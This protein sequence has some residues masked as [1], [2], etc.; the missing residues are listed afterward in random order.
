MG[1]GCLNLQ[2]PPSNPPVRNER[3]TSA[4]MTGF[5]GKST[6]DERRVCS[7]TASHVTIRMYVCV[8]VA[9]VGGKKMVQC[10]QKGFIEMIFYSDAVSGI[11]TSFK[12]NPMTLVMSLSTKIIIS[13]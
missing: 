9:V 12:W 6:C 8:V 2:L 7:S 13:K 5:M 4:D 11:E 1:M 3:S 10:G